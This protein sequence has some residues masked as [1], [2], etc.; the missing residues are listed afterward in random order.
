MTWAEWYRSELEAA[1]Q[2]PDGAAYARGIQRGFEGTQAVS[3]DEHRRLTA[4]RDS[5]V[6]Y[7]DG[8]LEGM[9]LRYW[10]TWYGPPE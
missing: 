5:A 8:L 1:R 3:D 2:R 4:D 9:N 10:S 7:Q 6:A